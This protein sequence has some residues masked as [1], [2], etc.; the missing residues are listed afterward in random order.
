MKLLFGHKFLLMKY[1]TGW[2]QESRHPKS[3]TGWKTYSKRKIEKLK[4]SLGI[5][6]VYPRGIS[7]IAFMYTHAC[8]EWKSPE[9]KV[10]RWDFDE[11]SIHYTHSD[12]NNW[13]WNQNQRDL[14]EIIILNFYHVQ[15]WPLF[16]GFESFFHFNL[17][18]MID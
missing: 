18:L 6:H 4:C 10:L 7:Q 8:L 15:F 16:M 2:W 1:L 3:K 5:L 11:L 13:I 14:K 9:I 12:Q 17:V